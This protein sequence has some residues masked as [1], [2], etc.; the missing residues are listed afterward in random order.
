MKRARSGT[1]AR[2]L[3]SSQYRNPGDQ[4]IISE[5][6]SMA[7]HDHWVNFFA[8]LCTS[9]IDVLHEHLMQIPYGQ[10]LDRIELVKVEMENEENFRKEQDTNYTTPAALDKYS[11]LLDDLW[12]GINNQ[13]LFISNHRPT[14]SPSNYFE[15][16]TDFDS[17]AD[18]NHNPDYHLRHHDLM[19]HQYHN[20]ASHAQHYHDAQHHV[21]HHAQHHAQ[22]HP[23]RHRYEPHY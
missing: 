8:L 18:Y 15:T 11:E 17:S 5:L 22:H 4:Q 13:I 6:G 19:R 16:D 23:Y 2:R 21:P 12:K 3:F 1:S 9:D 14:D 10:V 20:Q 7:T